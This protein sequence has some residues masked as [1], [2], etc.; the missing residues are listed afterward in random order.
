MSGIK[1]LV[2]DTNI[3]IYL[4]DGDT[5]LEELLNENRLVISVITEM[6]LLSYNTTP[7]EEKIIREFID[8]C[9]VIELNK[10]IKEHAISLRKRHKL[11]LPDGIVAATAYFM[12]IP[13]ITADTDFNRLEEIEILLYKL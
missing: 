13:L 3:I 9:Q 6:E 2:L 5:V 12:N 10:T 11:K 4:L 7:K 1:S 8:E